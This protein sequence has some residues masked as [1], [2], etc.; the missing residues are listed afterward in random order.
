MKNIILVNG[1]NF[2]YPIHQSRISLKIPKKHS[3]F[4]TTDTH[5]LMVWKARGKEMKISPSCT[6]QKKKEVNTCRSSWLCVCSPWLHE[7]L[8]ETP[9]CDCRCLN[10]PLGEQCTEF[11]HLTP[12][13]N[14]SGSRIGFKSTCTFRARSRLFFIFSFFLSWIIQ[15]SETEPKCTNVRTA[16]RE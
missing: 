8:A 9:S 5:F 10:S 12:K 14:Y 4:L 6:R 7:K 13:I 2:Q 3:Q 15:S 16:Q 1:R 11:Q